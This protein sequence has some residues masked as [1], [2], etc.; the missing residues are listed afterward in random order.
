MGTFCRQFDDQ[1]CQC[2]TYASPTV[3]ERFKGTSS[4]RSVPA[5]QILH[6][7]LVGNATRCTPNANETSRR[8]PPNSKVWDM[9]PVTGNRQPGSQQPTGWLVLC[10]IAPFVLS[11]VWSSESYHVLHP[12]GELSVCTAIYICNL[13]QA[14]L[15]NVGFERRTKITR[16]NGK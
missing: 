16:S 13:Q 9:G 11:A 1:C 10:R 4:K 3:R 15:V 12:H 2:A 14:F 5:T 6:V 8:T 7:G